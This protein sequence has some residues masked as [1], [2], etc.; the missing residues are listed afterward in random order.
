[1][2]SSYP[3][4]P[5]LRDRVEQFARKNSHIA[6]IETIGRTIEGRDVRAVIVTDKGNALENKEIVLVVM[7]RHGDELGTRAVALR[8]LEWLSSGQAKSILANQVII[9]IPVANPDGCANDTFGLPSDRISKL[10]KESVVQFGLSFVP[11]VVLDVHSVGKGKHGY[12]WGGLEA[13]IFDEAARFGEDPY[14]LH[15]LADLM[16]QGAARK[17][18]PFLLHRTGFY[19]DLRKKA[20]AI[21][22][23]AFNNHLNKIFYETCHALTFGIEVNH[24]V[25]NPQEAAESGLAAIVALL[26]TGNSAFQWESSPGYPNRILLGDFSASIRP[27]GKTAADRRTSRHEIWSHRLLFNSAF[28]PCRKM[29]NTHSVEVSFSFCGQKPLQ[30]GLT[31]AVRLRGRPRIERIEVN[32]STAPYLSKK[33]PCSIYLFIDLEFIEPGDIN[34]I[35][36]EF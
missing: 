24:F 10:E 33:D 27:R 14:I 11:D 30:G 21:A 7:G 20:A 2:C 23:D 31:A 4:W 29:E 12:N 15:T 6:H 35:I 5:E 8:L 28:T 36:L 17:G 34:K 16:I 22:H 1:M 19:R 26:K 3:S 13:V 32:G 18:F 25:L 9:V